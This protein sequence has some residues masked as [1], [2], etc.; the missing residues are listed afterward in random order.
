MKIIG[1]GAQSHT[2]T[3]ANTMLVVT[4]T[5]RTVEVRVIVVV[6]PKVAFVNVFHTV[7]VFTVT[8]L[9]A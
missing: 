2:W 8:V 9:R 6:I 1:D 5:V 7:E 4:N 3:G